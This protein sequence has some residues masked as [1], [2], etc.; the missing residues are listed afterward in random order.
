MET[1]I[2]EL[3]HPLLAEAAAVARGLGHGFVAPE[4]LLLAIVARREGASGRFFERRGLTAAA[5]RRE[6][7]AV[8]GPAGG[9]T[10]GGGP[11][12]LAQRAVVA[13]GDAV[14]AGTRGAPGTPAADTLLAALL[15]DDVA[16]D[17]VVG[18]VLERA[19]VTLADARAEFARAAAAGPDA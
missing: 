16:R 10:P 4:H 12:R 5:L 7:E 19:G 6:V 3:S 13:L 14:R 15:G 9:S 2:F 17:A 8:L 11:L 18:A 1:Q